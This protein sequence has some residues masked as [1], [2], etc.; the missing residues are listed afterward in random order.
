MANQMIGQG[1]DSAPYLSS[2]I[3]I[4][5]N[6]LSMLACSST[7]SAQDKSLAQYNYARSLLQQHEDNNQTRKRRAKDAPPP[8]HRNEIFT[9]AQRAVMNAPW[10]TKAWTLL[11]IA[12]ASM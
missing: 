9:A 5:A 4:S 12:K 7:A 2:T 8:D 1:H 3:S 6:S 11:G 10:D